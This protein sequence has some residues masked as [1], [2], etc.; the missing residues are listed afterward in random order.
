MCTA[1]RF[2]CLIKTTRIKFINHIIKMQ[3]LSKCKSRSIMMIRCNTFH[4]IRGVI[5]MGGFWSRCSRESS[6]CR[7]WLSR[8]WD[9]LIRIYT[10]VLIY[11]KVCDL[12]WGLI[13]TVITWRVIKVN[14]SKRWVLP[15]LS[16]PQTLSTSPDSSKKQLIDTKKTTTA[17]LPPNKR[18]RS[19]M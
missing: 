6:P 5:H 1:I 10:L 15:A 17:K 19:K 4:R 13:T 8:S 11:L 16:G 7:K 14:R 18:T 3:F 9:K 12:I 2:K